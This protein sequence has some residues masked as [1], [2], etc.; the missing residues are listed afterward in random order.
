VSDKTMTEPW[1]ELYRYWRGKH[2]DGRPPTRDAI[3]PPLEIPHLA[4]NLM[5]VD[6]T[7]QG[8]EYR[9]V[10]TNFAKG[11][12]IDMTGMAV[13]QSGLHAHVIAQWSRAMKEA[14]ATGEARLVVGRVAPH[15][16]A[17]V[18]MLM[19]PLTPSADGIP[20]IMGGMFVTGT[21]PPH[22]EIEALEL[23]PIID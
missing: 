8:L 18:E 13:G 5:L 12:G 15:I 2:V 6:V 11:A 23:Q 1:R 17:R 9:L 16:T 22:T 21:F 7:P 3:D 20:K 10:G 14:L 19:L 4:H